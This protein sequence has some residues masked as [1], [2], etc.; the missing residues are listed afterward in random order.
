MSR[1]RPVAPRTARRTAVLLAAAALGLAACTAGSGT[2]AEAPVTLTTTVAPTADPTTSAAA[3][4]TS[5]APSTSTSTSTTTETSAAPSTASAS[6]SAT[7]EAEA[8][9]TVAAPV[10]TEVWPDNSMVPHIFFHSLVVDPERAFNDAES[11]PGYLDYM[12][13]Q[14]EFAKILDQLY[15]KGYVLVSPHQLAT[16][17]TDGRVTPKPLALPVGKKPLVISIDDVSYYEYMDGDGFATDLFVAEDGRVRN[18]YTDARGVTT[19]GSYDV[20]P[21]VDDFVRAHPDFS[22]E[23]ARGVIALTG[24]NGV[25]GY[26]SSPSEYAGKN[27][28]LDADIVTAKG[29]ADAL[30]AEGW[31]FA[32]HS[33][34]HINF[35]DSS[36]G[37]IQADTA[38]W[39]ADVEPIVG[40]TDL[41]IYPFGADISGVPGYRGEKFDYLK[42]QGYSFFFNVDGS[43]PA[44]GQW[45][46]AYLRE[47]RI[48]I[49]GISMKA[50]VEGR[51]VLGEFFDVTSVLDPQR[52][53]S[54][55]GS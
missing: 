18:N 5:E 19:Q 1:R 48:N 42:S 54:I 50:A 10:A 35:T 17:E 44:W 33:W 26:R 37:G 11:G 2:S 55:A 52:P 46:D 39:K 16:V 49:D 29:V 41:L 8:T 24:Y 34:G 36:L 38:K 12:A 53:A 32:S 28:D 31:E 23:G 45:G 25:L 13:T 51:Q 9:S 6:A 3:T 43:V 21:M 7:S 15:A 4:T 20:M 30:K 22:H 14:S 40:P 27:P 47:A